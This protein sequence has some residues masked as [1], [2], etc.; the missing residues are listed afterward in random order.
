MR[1]ASP[2]HFYLH[3]DKGDSRGF[4]TN[5]ETFLTSICHNLTPVNWRARKEKKCARTFKEQLTMLCED[6]YNNVFFKNIQ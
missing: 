2:K 4:Q 5:F 1:D 6:C 3:K